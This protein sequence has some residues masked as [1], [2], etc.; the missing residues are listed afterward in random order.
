MLKSPFWCGVSNSGWSRQR[1][2]KAIGDWR[3]ALFRNLR[4]LLQPL[5]AT[6]AALFHEGEILTIGEVPFA[7]GVARHSQLD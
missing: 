5:D 7:P 3:L 6:G 2:P 4:T 1:R